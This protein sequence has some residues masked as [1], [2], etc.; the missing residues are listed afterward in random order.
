MHWDGDIMTNIYY[1]TPY[2][3]TPFGLVRLGPNETLTPLKMS[4]SQIYH[5]L[6]YCENLLTPT[7]KA[8]KALTDLGIEVNDD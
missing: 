8:K 7:P 2:V 6:K 1:G 3:N 5:Q 4:Y